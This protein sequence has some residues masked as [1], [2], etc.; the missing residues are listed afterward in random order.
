MQE[1]YPKMYDD[2]KKG[3]LMVIIKLDNKLHLNENVEEIGCQHMG[4]NKNDKEFIDLMKKNF[5][6]K[7]NWNGSS[8]KAIL[9]NF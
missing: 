5:G 4:I 8:A 7:F 3:Y 6:N 9:I 2:S 1:K